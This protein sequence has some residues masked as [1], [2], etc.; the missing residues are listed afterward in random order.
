MPSSM[1]SYLVGLKIV[2]SKSAIVLVGFTSRSPSSLASYHHLLHQESNP[3]F[4]HQF[5]YSISPPHAS[6]KGLQIKNG[7]LLGE[8]DKREK[9]TEA[10]LSQQCSTLLYLAPHFRILYLVTDNGIWECSERVRGREEGG[11]E[12]GQ[13][14]NWK[15]VGVKEHGS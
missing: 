1:A 15:G 5:N 2:L 7:K 8:M 14:E 13:S 12:C 6:H 9:Q 4:G 10:I 11:K 3:M